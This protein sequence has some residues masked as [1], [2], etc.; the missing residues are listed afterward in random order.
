MPR[1]PA[2]GVAQSKPKRAFFAALNLTEGD[3]HSIKVYR[4]MQVCVSS[5]NLERNHHHRAEHHPKDEARAARDRL[6]TNPA[7]LAPSRYPREVKMPYTWDDIIETAKHRAVLS[8]FRNAGPVTKPYYEQAHYIDGKNE[9]NWAIQWCLWHSFRMFRNGSGASVP[10]IAFE[11]ETP[12]FQAMRSLPSS[13]SGNSSGIGERDVGL[14][15]QPE[16]PTWLGRLNGPYTGPGM[17]ESP[18][19]RSSG[20]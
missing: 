19:W 10:R 4:H 6:A 16:T 13:S 1:V 8:I 17:P 12:D 20:E 9:E 14:V 11:H 2:H 7:G 5:C 18:S 15:V 3:G